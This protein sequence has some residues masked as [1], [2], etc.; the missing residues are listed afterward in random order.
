MK[1]FISSMFGY[2]GTLWQQRLLYPHFKS[3][4]VLHESAWCH[5]FS[6]FLNNQS[7]VMFCKQRKAAAVTISDWLV[8][9]R[10]LNTL[11]WQSEKAKS[12]A[13]RNEQLPFHSEIFFSLFNPYHEDCRKVLQNLITRVQIL[14]FR[15]QSHRHSLC[16][17]CQNVHCGFYKYC[18]LGTVL[19]HLK[20]LYTLFSYILWLILGNDQFDTNNCFILQYVYYYLLNVSS[21]IFS[22]SGDW[23]VL[24]QRLVSSLW[25]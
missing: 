13:F 22:S 19:I 7:P 18:F 14:S 1:N 20:L 24:M 10:I 3:Y 9:R 25:K 16:V 12:Y 17:L 8:E 5:L 2:N 15:F 11:W 23:I 21:I 6:T 4:V